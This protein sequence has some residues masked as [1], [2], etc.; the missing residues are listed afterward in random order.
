M[1]CQAR[2]NVADLVAPDIA[3]KAQ[4]QEHARNSEASGFSLHPLEN[5]GHDQDDA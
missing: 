5:P 4:A 2:A 3:T 1:E